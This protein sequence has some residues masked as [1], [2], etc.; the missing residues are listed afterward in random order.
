MYIE[1]DRKLSLGMLTIGY[2]KPES[3]L[4]AKKGQE[5]SFLNPTIY[6]TW[7]LETYLLCCLESIRAFVWGVSSLP[8]ERVVHLLTRYSDK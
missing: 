2:P 3:R 4:V 7:Q 8:L 6:H 5:L 1:G